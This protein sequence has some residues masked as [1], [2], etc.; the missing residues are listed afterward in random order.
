[1]S[2]R[3]QIT[4]RR[5]LP[6]DSAREVVAQKFSKLCT[7]LPPSARCHVVLDRLTARAHGDERVSARID[8]S[9]A[10]FHLCT[11]ASAGDTC[12]AIRDAFE[13]AFAQSERD[14]VAAERRRTLSNRSTSRRRLRSLPA[15]SFAT[16]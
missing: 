9:G 14:Q 3:V 8:I 13:R 12:S 10:G 1:M 7:R 2:T 6:S 15:R 4:F 5:I 11:V 16:P